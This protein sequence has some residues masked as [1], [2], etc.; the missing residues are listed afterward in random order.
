MNVHGCRWQTVF[1]LRDTCNKRRCQQHQPASQAKHAMVIVVATRPRNKC[2]VAAKTI[3]FFCKNEHVNCSLI[4]R[5]SV[6]TN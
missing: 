3:T 4:F 6:T 1:N 5:T 2:H